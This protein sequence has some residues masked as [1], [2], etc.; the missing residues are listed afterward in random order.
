MDLEYVL[1]VEP[2]RG[3]YS[4]FTGKETKAQAGQTTCPESQ[5]QSVYSNP[6]SLLYMYV[7]YMLTHI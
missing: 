7:F 1:E 4:Y 3:Y 6:I 5:S 2:A